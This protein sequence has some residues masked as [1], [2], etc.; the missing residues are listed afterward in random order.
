MRYSISRYIGSSAAMA[1]CLFQSTRALFVS[2]MAI[3]GQLVDLDFSFI[4]A[5]GF[6][7]DRF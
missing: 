5:V 2:K 7:D 6:A 3:N 4:F 1:I